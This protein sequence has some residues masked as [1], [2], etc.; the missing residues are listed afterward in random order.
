MGWLR[1]GRW[2]WLLGGTI[3]T[4]GRE[5]LHLV[6]P[7]DG[8]IPWSVSLRQHRQ[9]VLGGLLAH[10]AAV[11]P[12][13]PRRR[14]VRLFVGTGILAGSRRTAPW[15]RTPC[16]W[17]TPSGPG[18]HVCRGRRPR[19]PRR[20]D[21]LPHR[22]AVRR[23]G[24]VPDRAR[25]VGHEHPRVPPRLPRRGYRRLPALRRGRAGAACRARRGSSWSTRSGRLGLVVGSFEAGPRVGAARG[26]SSSGAGGVLASR[27]S[28]RRWSTPFGSCT[29]RPGA[30]LP[31]TRRCSWWACCWRCSA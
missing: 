14:E 13:T 4:A 26:C 15:R 8:G 16:C 23:P 21:R 7:A 29:R 27:R 3:G 28:A 24:T 9:A 20:G 12:E 31:P 11:E 19:R 17:P 18:D 2:A 10:L 22:E 30:V 25:E 1:L 6:L 5:G